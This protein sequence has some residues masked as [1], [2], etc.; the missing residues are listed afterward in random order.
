MGCA[1]RPREDSPPT[2]VRRVE[3]GI[4][5]K[6]ERHERGQR[7]DADEELW[8]LTRYRVQDKL[9]GSAPTI[10]MIYVCA[11]FHGHTHATAIQG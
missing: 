10:Y 4:G 9:L 2:G 8:V 11:K 7:N 5:D 6:G 3:T 1:A